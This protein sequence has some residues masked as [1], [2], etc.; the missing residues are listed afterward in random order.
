MARDTLFSIEADLRALDDLID[1]KEGDITS[2]EAVIKAWLEELGDKLE[3]KIDGY[4]ALIA[5]MEARAEARSVEAKRLLDL[6]VRDERKA[7]QLRGALKWLFEARGLKTVETPR[8]RL[9]LRANG[10]QAPLEVNA[11]P[12]ELPDAFTRTT[13]SIDRDA[14]R[15][16]LEEGIELP[17]ARILPRKTNLQIK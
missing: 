6:S 10:G 13:R 11:T 9:T 1:E 17:F 12:D 7:D 4:C 16:I 15:R 5:E 8:Y 2:V 3:G 14:I